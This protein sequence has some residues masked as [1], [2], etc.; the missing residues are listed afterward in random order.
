MP[1]STEESLSPQEEFLP[2]VT[3]NRE[4]RERKQDKSQRKPRNKQQ[5]QA[6]PATQSRLASTLLCIGKAL[7][8]RTRWSKRGRKRGLFSRAK[9]E[10]VDHEVLSEVF[11]KLGIETKIDQI[12]AEFNAEA[13]AARTATRKKEPVAAI[14]PKEQDLPSQFDEAYGKIAKYGRHHKLWSAAVCILGVI[15]ALQVAFLS[16]HAIAH[17]FPGTRPMLVSLC[18]TLGCA[19][20]LPSDA[21]KIILHGGGFLWRSDNRYTLYVKMENSA[22]FEQSWPNLEL[23]L[24]NNIKQPL[25]RRILTP[26]DWVPPE[27]LSQDAGMAPRSIIEINME[28][29]VTG[30]VPSNYDLGYFYP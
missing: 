4:S 3:R 10:T 5:K 28:L 26:A 8:E 2:S 15:F 19:M 29:E 27:K 12:E 20:P 7:E 25:S 1:P 17:S 6:K 18:K 11:S 23:T 30:F 13:K 22:S 21:S 14:P 16:R 24:K 9:N